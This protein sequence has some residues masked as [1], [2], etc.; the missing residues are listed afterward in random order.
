[1]TRLQGRAEKGKRVYDSVPLNRGKNVTIIGAIALKGLVAFINI[2]GA[3]N[4]LV[5][6]AFI[7]TLLML[8][9]IEKKLSSQS[10]KKPALG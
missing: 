7:A 4:G 9:F 3:A 2:F 5:F 6:E 8:L 1:M 10:S